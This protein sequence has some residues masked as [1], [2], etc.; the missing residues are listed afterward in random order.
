MGK[1]EVDSII[2][3]CSDSE[4]GCVDVIDLWHRQ[5]GWN[6]IG[7]HFVITNGRLTSDQGY[8]GFNDGLIQT[9]RYINLVGA[10]CKGFNKRS[11]G[12][13]LIGKHGFTAKQLYQALPELLGKLMLEYDISIE[14]V[15]GHCEFSKAKTCPN[16]S[17]D[18]IRK[19][20]EYSV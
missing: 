17:P 18:I 6:G 4:F 1:R 19:I 3:H 15:R 7:Y 9:G 12:I 11:I 10:H 13:C 5:R 2:I 14:Q 16:I 20:A 8:S